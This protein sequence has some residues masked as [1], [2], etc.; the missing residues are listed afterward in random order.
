MLTTPFASLLRCV[1]LLAGVASVFVL[2]GCETEPS[3]PTPTTGSPC[4]EDRNCDSAA[5]CATDG[6]CRPYRACNPGSCGPDEVC[7]GSLCRFVDG[8]TFDEDCRRD[9]VC[10][11]FNECDPIPLCVA[12]EQCTAASLGCGLNGI[13]ASD[14]TD[15]GV[16]RCFRDSHCLSGYRC[17]PDG[18]CYW[19]AFC[20][21]DLDCPTGF[22][23]TTIGICLP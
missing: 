18:L 16:D 17:A 4:F 21:E 1:R 9:E 12:D 3:R 5:Y 13:C 19:R 11:P 23:C 6:V 10:G 20:Q 2:L 7:D 8:C 14:S 22:F 15:T